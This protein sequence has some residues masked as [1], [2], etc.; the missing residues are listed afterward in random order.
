MMVFGVYPVFLN[1]L[2]QYCEWVYLCFRSQISSFV[3]APGTTILIKTPAMTKHWLDLKVGQ[4]S[5]EQ[6]VVATDCGIAAG[7]LTSDAYG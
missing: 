5:T 1:I 7:L 2:W 6:A 3:Q 4:L